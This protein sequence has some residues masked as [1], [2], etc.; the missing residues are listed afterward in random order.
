MRLEVFMGPCQRCGRCFHPPT[1]LDRMMKTGFRTVWKEAERDGHNSVALRRPDRD[2]EPDH[3][4]TSVAAVEMRRLK[5]SAVAY[6]C[7]ALLMVGLLIAFGAVKPGSLLVGRH[8][9]GYQG[10]THALVPVSVP[11][12][13]RRPRVEASDRAWAFGDYRVLTD[14]GVLPSYSQPDHP[15]GAD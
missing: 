9:A 15:P 7:Q 11:E 2:A 13:N 10:H 4:I 1:P 12:G 3:G 6:L 14:A 8:R 5:L